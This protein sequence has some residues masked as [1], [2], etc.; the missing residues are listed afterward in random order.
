M[1]LVNI[2]PLISAPPNSSMI[3][4][5]PTV[6]LGD[7]VSRLARVYGL[8]VD[9]GPRQA[10]LSALGQNAGE[11]ETLKSY[12]ARTL[13]GLGAARAIL[14]SRSPLEAELLD[15]LAPQ[16]Q[17]IVLGRKL[18]KLEWPPFALLR[19]DFPDR[20]TVGPI[21]LTGPAR[22][23]YYGPY[24]ALPR[25]RW[26]ADLVLE[27][28]DCFSDNQIAIDVVSGSVLAAVKARLPVQGVYGCELAFDILAPSNPIEIRMQLL[29]GAIEGMLMLRSIRLNRLESP[30][31]AGETGSG[32][33]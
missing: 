11:D 31:I 27:V 30:A 19:P 17:P 18:E 14:D 21:E 16:Y 5:V 29:T 33:H 8:S 15:L 2:E 23:I 1:G 13:L 22:F 24:F 25:G 9:D 7:L 32:A 10:I 4:D 12:A 28:S 6:R 20:L 26:R 3:V